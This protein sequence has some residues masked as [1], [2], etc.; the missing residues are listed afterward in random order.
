MFPAR[1]T[2]SPRAFFSLRKAFGTGL[3]NS[4]EH[5]RNKRASD[6]SLVFI[7]VRGVCLRG[8]LSLRSITMK[9][10]NVYAAGLWGA[11][12][13]LGFGFAAGCAHPAADAGSGVTVN[14]ATPVISAGPLDAAYAYGAEAEALSVTASVNDGGTLSYQWYKN[15]TGSNDGGVKVGG[16]SPSYTPKIAPSGDGD[17]HDYY[18][19]WVTNT[20]SGVNGAKTVVKRSEVADIRTTNDTTLAN[21]AMPVIS[22]QPLD[23]DYTYGGTAEALTVTAS[24][25]DGGTLTYQWYK[26][27]EPSTEGASPIS[28]ATGE[29]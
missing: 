9:K 20:N 8:R 27:T 7:T 25:G 17:T 2:L 18:Y 23:A 19:V 13:A 16:N 14:A 10:Q 6:G 3:F 21:A 28:G 22:D 24:A 12:L 15:A 29:S 4:P 26:N 1:E 5:E 11:A